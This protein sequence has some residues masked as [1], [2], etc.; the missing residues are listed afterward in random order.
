MAVAMTVGAI[1]IAIVIVTALLAA[2]RDNQEAGPSSFGPG[3]VTHAQPGADGCRNITGEVCYLVGVASAFPNLTV[4]NLFFAV[5]ADWPASYPEPNNVPLGPEA[6]AS[7]VTSSGLNGVWS[8]T[9]NQWTIA[10]SGDVPTTE[11]LQVGLD[12]G[13]Q[14]ADSLNG[15]Y[16]SVEHSMPYGGS[17]GFPLT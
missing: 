12:T 7:I 1:L 13:L 3:F 15:S 6:S 11:Q 4:S 16:F 8:F 5:S 2:L 14:S 9:A 17:V 10:P